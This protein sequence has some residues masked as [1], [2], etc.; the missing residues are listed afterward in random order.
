MSL[1]NVLKISELVFSRKHSEYLQ[2]QN[3]IYGGWAS[4]TTVD[5]EQVFTNWVQISH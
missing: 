1:K 4:V 3:N 5:L 2:F